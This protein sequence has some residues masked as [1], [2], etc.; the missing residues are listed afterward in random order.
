MTVPGRESWGWEAGHPW[1]RRCSSWST[2]ARSSV[3][4]WRSGGEWREPDRLVRLF[5]RRFGDPVPI[6]VAGQPYSPE[7]LTA[8]LLRWVVTSTAEREGGPPE[9]V[10]LTH[11]ANWGAYRRERFSQ[12]LTLADVPDSFTR[13]EPEA[14]ATQ[15]A[16]HTRLSPGDKVAVY[17][18]GGGKFDVCVLEK[19][20]Q[21]FRIIGQ[22]DGIE[23]LGGI[24]FDEAVL[25][26]VLRTVDSPLNS[27]DSAAPLPPTLSFGSDATA[28][29]RRRRCRSTSRQ[30]CPYRCRVWQPRSRS[31]GPNSRISSAR[32][33]RTRCRR[34][35]GRFGRRTRQPNSSR[36]SCS[37]VGAPGSPS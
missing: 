22:P 31:P 20:A 27:M 28:R 12:S 26:H 17:D 15:Y 36:R 2:T 24:D 19:Q 3:V 25:Q 30:W 5:K 4:R 10:V 35:A 14:A 8:T 29:R 7:A 1:C 34:C 9:L 23:H 33:S 18:L 21:G 32:R 16:A 6:L 13:T 11:P 37:W